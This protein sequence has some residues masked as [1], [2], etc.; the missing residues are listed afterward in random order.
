MRRKNISTRRTPAIR[1]DR[2]MQ[3]RQP[4]IVRLTIIIH[5]RNAFARRLAH[6]GISRLGEA[7][8]VARHTPDGKLRNHQRHVRRHRLH[9][10][11]LIRPQ[12]ARRQCRKP[13]RQQ[14]IAAPRSQDHDGDFSH[15]ATLVLRRFRESE[16]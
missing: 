13:A 12:R 5:E 10:D 6:P 4:F 3:P 9:Q 7:P 2:I 16:K 14:F 1:H 8:I 11:H 15:E